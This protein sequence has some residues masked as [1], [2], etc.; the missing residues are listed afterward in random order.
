MVKKRNSNVE[1]ELKCYVLQAENFFPA[2][3]QNEC[4][5]DGVKEIHLSDV[6]NT[7]ISFMINSQVK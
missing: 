6:L 5:E 1:M 3:T 4:K 7:D 2:H